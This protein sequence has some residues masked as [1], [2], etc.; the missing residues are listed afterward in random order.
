[1]L[2][3]PDIIRICAIADAKVVSLEPYKEE[4]PM[5]ETTKKTT[6][7]TTTKKEPATL[8]AAVLQARNIAEP[9]V[10]DSHCSM[11]GGGYKY[12]STETVLREAIPILS[13]CGLV[14]MPQDQQFTSVGEGDNSCPAMEMTFTLHHIASGETLH[15][16]HSLPVENMRTPTKGSLAVRTTAF[17]YV[18]RDILALPRVDERQAEVDNP[19]GRPQSRTAESRPV[20][21]KPATT[22][23]IQYIRERMAE[24]PNPEA[25]LK[26]L[27]ERLN[28]RYGVTMETITTDVADAVISQ[29]ESS[30][31]KE[32]V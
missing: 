18:I 29:F 3:D 27:N 11:G 22:E 7:K 2:N 1:M 21:A 15:I 4:N 9:I 24:A 26:S 31:E 13:E 30:K 10:K 25:F 8:W 23:Q 16:K 6:K 32:T 17:Q 28:A 5:P 14:L 19:D 20:T 12:L